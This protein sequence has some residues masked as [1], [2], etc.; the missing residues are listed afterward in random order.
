MA[1]KASTKSSGTRAA[2]GSTSAGGD[3]RRA[4]APAV[5][6]PAPRRSRLV[7]TP[8]KGAR[9]KPDVVRVPVLAAGADPGKT[10]PSAMAVRD[11]LVIDRQLLEDYHPDQLFAYDVTRE[12][13]TY[14]RG[15]A[16]P[17]DRIVFRRGGRATADRICAVRTRAGVVLARIRFDNHALLLLPGEGGRH[18]EPLALEEVRGQLGAVAGTHVLLIRR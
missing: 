1:K 10:V 7:A 12:S 13:M 8:P 16:S 14:L 11:R 18:A 17:G 5:P 6:I 2:A 9:A 15:L 4:T 3:R